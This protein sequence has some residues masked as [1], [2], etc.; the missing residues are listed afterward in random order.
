MLDVNV[1]EH[2]HCRRVVDMV[3]PTEI[4]AAERRAAL[5]EFASGVRVKGFRRGR[6]PAR[7]LAE[8]SPELQE[9]VCR[10]LVHES[11]AA[12][13]K[14]RDLEPVG[15]VAVENIRF[16][17]G[18]PLSFRA[19]FDVMPEV[20]IKRV[21]GFRQE[22]P[23]AF[24]LDDEEL[25][26]QLERLRRAQADWRRVEDG[27]PE[28]GDAATVVISR[29]DDAGLATDERPVDGS[30]AGDADAD[31][32]RAYR[33][34][35][36]RS[37]AL[38]GI[39][40]AVESLTPRSEGVFEVAFPG[41]SE[42]EPGETRTLRIRLIEREVPELPEMNDDFAASLGD[43]DSL[44]ALRDDMRSRL[45]E[46]RR[47]VQKQELDAALVRQVI[48]ANDFQ[49]PRSMVDDVLERRIADEEAA[50]EEDAEQL[51][52]ELWDTAE[53]AVKYFL[54]RKA[55]VEKFGLAPT[56]EELDEAVEELAEEIGQT[57]SRLYADL[58]KSG[59]MRDFVHRIED[60]KVTEFLR[61]RSP[62][63]EE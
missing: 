22:P 60:R 52:V 35:L 16:R 9:K 43:F 33:F 29:V 7:V 31:E 36:G 53:A 19:A 34:V 63:P 54:F 25:N 2:P 44:E 62:L 24:D 59:E 27:A 42:L 46:V 10:K 55:I 6:V 8:H 56:E 26:R 32:Q 14:E 30:G 15:T 50:T 40:K 20:V 13:V 21:H 45:T 39:E 18:E 4:V 17:P 61:S 1:T 38:P 12:V 47:A 37:Q 51:K 28:A 11:V 41:S 49:V 23:P 48:E 5:R 57:P 3:V 58:Q